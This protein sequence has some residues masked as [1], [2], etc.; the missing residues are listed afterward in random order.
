MIALKGAGGNLKDYFLE[1]MSK[2]AAEAF[3][4]ELGFLGPTKVKDVEEAQRKIVDEVQ[5]LVEKGLIQM[6]DADEVI[7]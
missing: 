2:R 6:G 7:D 3:E 4:E 5:K 1:N